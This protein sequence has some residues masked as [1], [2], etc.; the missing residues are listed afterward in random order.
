MDSDKDLGR[1]SFRVTSMNAM[2][3]SRLVSSRSIDH[4]FGTAARTGQS[5]Y[6]SSSLA[7]TLNDR[8]AS[9]NR[10]FMRLS[11]PRSYECWAMII[12]TFGNRHRDYIVIGFL[13]SWVLDTKQRR[14]A[15]I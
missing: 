8:S 4:P 11:L 9:S 5:D 6:C 15:D 3:S 13:P 12:L 1:R 7:S 14:R 10:S 2:H